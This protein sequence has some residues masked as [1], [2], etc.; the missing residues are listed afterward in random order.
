[1]GNG[2][3][4]VGVSNQWMPYAN[5]RTVLSIKCVGV[6]VECSQVKNKSTTAIL[7]WA[8]KDI[9]NDFAWRVPGGLNDVFLK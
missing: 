2:H 1:M 3:G 6:C 8:N 5:L 4:V 7:F 9:G